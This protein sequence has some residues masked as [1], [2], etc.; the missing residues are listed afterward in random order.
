MRAPAESSALPLF[1]LLVA[2]L[3]TLERLH[4]LDGLQRLVEVIHDV[5]DERADVLLRGEA[6]RS[7][8][9]GSRERGLLSDLFLPL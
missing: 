1:L 3:Q 5:C 4:V 9:S 6:E 8:A 7:D 2:A